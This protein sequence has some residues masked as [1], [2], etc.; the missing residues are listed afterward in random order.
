[1]RLPLPRSDGEQLLVARE[2]ERDHP[3]LGEPPC[4]DW[5]DGGKCGTSEP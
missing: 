3:V 5:G 2:G 4:P 1:M